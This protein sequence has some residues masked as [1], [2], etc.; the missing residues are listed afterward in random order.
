MQLYEYLSYFLMKFILYIVFF[1]AFFMCVFITYKKIY[2]IIFFSV[3]CLFWNS[4]IRCNKVSNK[5]VNLFKTSYSTICIPQN[6]WNSKKNIPNIIRIFNTIWYHNFNLAIT[7]NKKVVWKVFMVETR[8]IFFFQKI[9]L[10]A[11][12]HICKTLKH[13]QNM[14]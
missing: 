3:V 12:K 14:C 9:V 10:P 4:I 13:L 1:H 8:V 11:S 6:Y 7:S 2:E 5:K